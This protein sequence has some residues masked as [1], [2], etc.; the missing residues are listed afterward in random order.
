MLHMSAD[1]V[2]KYAQIKFWI[3]F[4]MYNEYYFSGIIQNS[5]FCV[6]VPAPSH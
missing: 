4:S 1:S 6:E 3:S 5:D 2:V